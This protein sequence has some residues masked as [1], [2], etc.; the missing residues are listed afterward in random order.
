MNLRQRITLHEGCPVLPNGNA[1]LYQDSKGNWTIG[2]GWHI[3]EHGLPMHLVEQL[4]DISLRNAHIE[5]HQVVGSRGWFGMNEARQ[6]VVIEAVFWMGASTFR[7]FRRTIQAIR[8]ADW[9]NAAAELLD[10]KAGREFKTRMTR[11]AD[12]MRTGVEQAS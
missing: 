10:S 7:Q 1:R 5:A 12:V 2:K 8:R 3:G 11:L 4:F 9:K 6:G